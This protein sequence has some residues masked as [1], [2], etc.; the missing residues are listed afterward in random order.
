MMLTNYVRRDCKSFPPYLRSN[1]AELHSSGSHKHIPFAIGPSVGPGCAV[2]SRACSRC[3]ATTRRETPRLPRLRRPAMPIGV[4]VGPG[5]AVQSRACY[6]CPAT[7]PV[8]RLYFR[9]F[10]HQRC[11]R[12][13]WPLLFLSLLPRHLRW[14]LA[15]SSSFSGRN[16]NSGL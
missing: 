3:P 11:P 14:F 13:R 2:Q 1:G 9:V 5:C 16:R 4:S 7:T 10:V 6:R 8:G 12:H 15:I